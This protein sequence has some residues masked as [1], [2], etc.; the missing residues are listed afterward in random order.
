MLIDRYGFQHSTTSDT[1]VLAFEQ[2][3]ATVAA[4]RPAAQLLPMTLTHAPGLPGALALQGLAAVITASDTSLAISRQLAAQSAAALIEVGGGTASERGLVE[5]H[6]VASHGHL[7]AA[8]QR[9]E[10]HIQ[11]APKDFMAIKLAHALRFMSGQ[12]VPMLMT[13]VAVLPEWRVT[14]AGYGYLLGCHAFSL[15]ESGRFADAERTGR[16]AV[17]YAPDDVWGIH[18][19]AHVMEMGGRTAEGNRLAAVD[20]GHAVSAL[21]DRR[22]RL[23]HRLV[24]VRA[25]HHGPFLRGPAAIPW[26]HPA[27]MG[28]A[29]QPY[30]VRDSAG[31]RH[32][33]PPGQVGGEVV[34]SRSSAA[35]CATNGIRR[36]RFV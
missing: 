36:G 5:A 34:S 28:V 30:G 33:S 25:L 22:Y 4:H 27:D 6:C 1:A 10:A 14:D 8:A 13:L 15:E 3:V 31:C 12:I 20:D 24:G 35:P 17:T 32:Q 2:V 29:D 26:L 23:W 9:L 21:V 11:T 16:R 19:V 18:A 7:Q